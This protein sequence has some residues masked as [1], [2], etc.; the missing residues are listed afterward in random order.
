VGYPVFG[1][2]CIATFL[3]PA[4]VGIKRFTN[5]GKATRILAI[6]SFIA[7]LEIVAAEIASWLIKSNYLITDTYRG[8]EASLLCAFFYYCA[9]ENR[10]RY[11]LKTMGVVFSLAWIVDLVLMKNPG[12]INSGMA[13][14]SRLVLI[15]MSSVA[16]YSL[17]ED[18]SMNPMEKPV[19]WV[20]V[21]VMLYA[22]GTLVILALSNYL[23]KLGLPY[24]EAGW[25]VNWTLLILSNL[26]YT[27][28]MMCK[29]QM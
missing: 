17:L 1:Y 7:C 10:S 2:I 27:K 13:I 29:Y 18:E 3:V 23:L 28:A 22:A 12:H 19:F 4:A 20:A 26:L 14:V 8:I 5:L 21:G 16:L 6:L 25:R 11:L 9:K 24:F 15:A